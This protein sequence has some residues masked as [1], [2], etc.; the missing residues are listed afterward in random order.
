[1]VAIQ[2][3]NRD[4]PEPEPELASGGGGE[5]LIFCTFHHLLA[6]KSHKKEQEVVAAAKS[7]GHAGLIVYGTPG[8]VVLHRAQGADDEREFLNACRKIGK[9][10]A[11]KSPVLYCA[12]L[13]RALRCAL[14]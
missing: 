8:V 10:V 2:G 14:L 1:M 6:G 9:K 7:L 11:D 12:V 3:G 5:E 4:Q 13:C